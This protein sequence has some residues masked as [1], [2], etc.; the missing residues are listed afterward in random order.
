MGKIK[1][2]LSSYIPLYFIL[3]IKNVLLKFENNNWKFNNLYLINSLDS[4]VIIV[5]CL[6]IIYLLC[7]LIK[8]DKEIEKNAINRYEI[9]KV[10][11]FSTEPILNY[12]SL[13]ILTFIEFDFNYI[14]NIVTLI[15][16]MIFFGIITIKYN[17]LYIN[18][19]F[20]LLG[21]KIYDLTLKEGEKEVEELV[22]LK[23]KIQ[24]EN[25]IEIYDSTEKYCFGRL[26]KE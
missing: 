6:L 4:W 19:V 14:S 18:P 22:L 12:V 20:L 5:L 17:E 23:E 9:L 16:L 8:Q 7:D 26:V 13:Y 2:Y 24:D 21:Y 10:N 1:I 15:L 11:D 25:K 3:V